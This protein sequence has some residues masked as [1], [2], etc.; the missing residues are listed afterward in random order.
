[1]E[2]SPVFTATLHRGPHNLGPSRSLTDVV[3][4]AQ[5]IPGGGTDSVTS[6]F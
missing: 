4:L 2:A 3:T 1:M 5:S 6:L